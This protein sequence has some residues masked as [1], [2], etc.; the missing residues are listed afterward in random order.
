MM[1]QVIELFPNLVEEL[2]KRPMTLC[3]GDFSSHNIL[4]A[5]DFIGV[6]DW[7]RCFKGCGL[8]DL[9]FV[10]TD[11]VSSMI[12]NTFENDLVT[13]YHQTLVKYGITNYPLV[14]CQEDYNLAKIW[15]TI[16]TFTGGVMVGVTQEQ[17]GRFTY[18]MEN[19]TNQTN[20]ELLLLLTKK[21]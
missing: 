4:F 19:F 15:A 7:Q 8:L 16:V 5:P 12:R 20:K 10:I 13:V 1:D 2:A 6:I 21:G 17:W 18:N 11:S 9:A 3:H 14:V